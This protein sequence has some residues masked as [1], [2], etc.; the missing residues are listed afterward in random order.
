MK[1]P[2]SVIILTFNEEENIETC[3]NSV[4]C[5]D[6]VI[7]LDSQSTDSTCSIA[8]SKG[9]RVFERPF[10][11]YANQRNYALNEIE[12]KYPW[13]L[14]LDADEEVTQELLTEINNKLSIVKD[15]VSLFRL[16]RKDYFMGRWLKYSTNYSSLW[17]GRL[18]RLGHVWIEREINEEFHT[19]GKIE[20][21]DG[22]IVHYPFNKGI[23]QWLEKHNRYSTM[24]A[25]HLISE[26]PD[27]YEI[28]SLLS[29]DPVLRRKTLKSIVYSLP[30]R[31]VI[32]FF[33]RYIF[34][35]GFLDGKAG[36]S[37][38]ILKSIY[39]YMISCKV[40]ELQRKKDGM[41]L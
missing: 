38:S 26:N 40:L 16:R 19:D 23:H 28:K 31:P 33:G 3:L 24:E 11:N 37:Y 36:L 20:Q 30:G 8:K 29:K 12:Y 10:D 39:E 35:K 15:D 17:F 18:M 25:E 41:S 14:M 21:L 6:D 7:V 2:V 5:C 13:V 22:A 1:L 4:S 27:S 34:A 9:A 32:M